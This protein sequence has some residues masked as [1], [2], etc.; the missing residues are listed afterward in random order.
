MNLTTHLHLVLRSKYVELYL[1]SPVR[2]HGM[3]L[4]STETTLPLPYHC[5]INPIF[6]VWSKVK[7]Y[8]SSNIHL[9][10]LGMEAVTN[11]WK[12][13][14]QQ[15][16]FLCSVAMKCTSSIDLSTTYSHKKSAIYI[17]TILDSVFL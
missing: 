5:H 1:H 14:L 8:Y 3:G 11:M 4:I 10:G 12:E 9:T 15:V 17:Y 6:L 16:C 2:L 7:R 13:S